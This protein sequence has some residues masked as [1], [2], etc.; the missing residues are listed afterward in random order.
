MVWDICAKQ[1]VGGKVG[2]HWDLLWNNDTLPGIFQKVQSSTCVFAI[3]GI[4]PLCSATLSYWKDS[5]GWFRTAGLWHH[6][7]DRCNRWKRTPFLLCWR[8]C[9]PWRHIKMCVW[10]SWTN[11]RW[12]PCPYFKRA[13]FLGKHPSF[14][15]ITDLA[16]Q[17][18]FSC[19]DFTKLP[20]WDWLLL[21]VMTQTVTQAYWVTAIREGVWVYSFAFMGKFKCTS[22]CWITVVVKHLGVIYSKGSTCFC[23]LKK[24]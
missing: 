21:W 24:T 4:C 5:S 17:K 12:R 22:K 9:F 18:L 11:T 16:I 1:V 15:R 7:S 8:T 19:A 14:K 13:N 3:P 20:L 2:Q 10:V 23:M 6:V